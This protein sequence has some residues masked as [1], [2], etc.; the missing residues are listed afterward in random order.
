MTINTLA[1]RSSSNNNGGLA[2]ASDRVRENPLIGRINIKH[3]DA[4]A[5]AAVVAERC[6]I[7]IS[8]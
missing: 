6:S 7:L 4:V 2:V 1:A 3:G 8:A 5:P